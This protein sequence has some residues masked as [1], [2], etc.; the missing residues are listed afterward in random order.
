MAPNN[1]MRMPLLPS[2]PE[3]VAARKELGT[4]HSM[5]VI[6]NSGRMAPGEWQNA[7]DVLELLD[8]HITIAQAKVDELLPSEPAAPSDLEQALAARARDDI[9]P[10]APAIPDLAGQH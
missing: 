7:R 8:K 5:N 6:I 4:W 10:D 1:V 9:D 2:S 3:L